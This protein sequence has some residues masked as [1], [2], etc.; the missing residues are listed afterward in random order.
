[1]QVA[2]DCPDLDV[3]SCSLCPISWLEPPLGRSMPPEPKLCA[4]CAAA[5][6][7]VG[8]H[9]TYYSPLTEQ[10]P[11]GG[12]S[13]ASDFSP[14][15]QSQPPT[16]LYFPTS[17]SPLDAMQYT[18]TLE[19]GFPRVPQDASEALPSAWL[20]QSGRWL[21]AHRENLHFY[22]LLPVCAFS[23]QWMYEGIGPTLDTADT[24]DVHRSEGHSHRAR[25]QTSLE[26]GIR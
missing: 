1:M 24:S 23:D 14:L 17:L 22:P 7:L 13:T 12:E 4:S 18:P 10:M 11:W 26:I 3:L 9:Q 21:R 15:Y 2:A 16:L 5:Q 6:V 8:L 25:S 20:D 19:S